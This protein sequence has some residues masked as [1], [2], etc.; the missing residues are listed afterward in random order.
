L[1]RTP[2]LSWLGKLESSAKDLNEK[3]IKR[4]PAIKLLDFMRFITRSDIAIRASGKT[5]S[6]AGGF[7]Q[8]ATGVA[9]RV[10]PTMKE[11]EPLSSAD[12]AQWVNY[13]KAVGMFQ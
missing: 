8:F 12:A 5:H 1:L 11:L 7:S 4:I 10:S 2:C 13:W 3:N 9:E 6:E